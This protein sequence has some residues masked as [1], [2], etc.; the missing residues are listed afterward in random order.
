MKEEKKEENKEEKANFGRS[1]FNANGYFHL[2]TA[3][4]LC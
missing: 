3:W 4:P 2:R 1:I